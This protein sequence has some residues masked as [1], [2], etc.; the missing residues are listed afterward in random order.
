MNNIQNKHLVNRTN[1]GCFEMKQMVQIKVGNMSYD[2]YFKN[3][4]QR[5]HKSSG[6][7]KINKKG[8]GYSVR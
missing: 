2:R 5:E 4:A 7:A 1:I 3:I 8:I 6:H